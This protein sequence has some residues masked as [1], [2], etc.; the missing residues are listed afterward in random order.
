MKKHWLRG[1]LLGVSLALLLAGGVALGN[2]VGVPATGDED[3]FTCYDG[4][5]ETP[6]DEYRM[7]IEFEGLD[8]GDWLCTYGEVLGGAYSA[9]WPFSPPLT[10]SSC[11]LSWWA[12]CDGAGGYTTDCVDANGTTAL[13]VHQQNGIPE[14]FFG[15]WS[16]WAWQE[17]FGCSAEPPNIEPAFTFLFAH[18]CEEEF[19]PEPGSILLLGSGLVGLAGYASLRRRARD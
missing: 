11:S 1:I 5:A 10:G 16:W 9:N 12:Y 4:T 6:P 19:V 2:G 13:E 17:D 8:T 7:D 3:C 14:G 18:V 15:E